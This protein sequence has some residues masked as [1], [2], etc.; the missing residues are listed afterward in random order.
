[1]GMRVLIL[2]V[3]LQISVFAEPN[4][5]APHC[6]F[7]DEDFSTFLAIAACVT[8]SYV[9]HHVWPLTQSQVRADFIQAIAAS[10]ELSPKPS[11]SDIDQFFAHFSR[12]ELTPR[13][14]DLILAVCYQAAGKTCNHRMLIHPGQSTEEMLEASVELK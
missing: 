4:N 9:E 8:N 13:G 6:A 3:T 1:M 10:A 14:R 5:D 12:I 7:A 2:L 11:A